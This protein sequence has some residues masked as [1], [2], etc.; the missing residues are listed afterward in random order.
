MSLRKS[1]LLL[2]F[3]NLSQISYAESSK[4]SPSTRKQTQSKSSSREKRQD[5]SKESD[6]ASK[7]DNGKKIELGVMYTPLS[8]FMLQYGASGQYKVSSKLTAGAAFLMGSK[9]ISSE[10]SDSTGSA[11]GNATLS[12]TAFMGYGRYFFGKTFNM[13]GGLAYR[14]A[15]IKYQIQDSTGAAINGVL[16]IQSIAVPI[17]IGNLWVFNNGIMLSADWI[18]AFF[19]PGIN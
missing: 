15:S 12:G 5:P 6:S 4:S 18:G 1:I 3:M 10:Q 2:A 9:T 7:D 17:F 14:G 19:Q 16:D 13:L 11:Q 8:D